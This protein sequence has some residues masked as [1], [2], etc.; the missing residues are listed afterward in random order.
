MTE[1]IQ[2]PKTLKIK[3]Q[4]AFI[5][6]SFYYVGML[7][8]NML[9]CMY[10]IKFLRQIFL[11]WRKAM[12]GLYID[13]SMGVAGDMLMSA[14]VELLPDPGVFLD[15]MNSLNLPKLSYELERKETCGIVGSHVKV[16]IEG[17]EENDYLHEHEHDHHHDHEHHHHDH[18]HHHHHDHEH[19]HHEHDH[20]QDHQHHKIIDIYNIIDNLDLDEQ[21]K[22]DA[23]AIYAMIAS[24]ESQV[25]GEE[26]ENIH[27]H[28]VGSLDAVA[29][30]VGNCILMDMLKPEVVYTS[31]VHV[32]SGTVRCA[33]GI[34]PVPAPAT[35]KILR[36]VP[37]Y[38][39]GIKGELCTP[40]GAALVKYFTTKFTDVPKMVIEKDGYG[41][42]TKDFGQANCV[43]V[44]C[45]EFED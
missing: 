29:D 13:C 31:A 25:H 11:N 12:K 41:I 27:F 23:K 30:V 42:G 1:L 16:M 10:E 37:I 24:A 26:M 35:A 8:R 44:M 45:C 5:P 2:E 36:G 40:T 22:N 7:A 14:L 38:S 21:V 43:R 32:G 28:E 19:Q 15:K 33:H 17:R 9:I 3:R 20:H 4:G 6:A 39:N 34:L 18:D